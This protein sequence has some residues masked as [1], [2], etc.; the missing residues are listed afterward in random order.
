MM[1]KYKDI[2]DIKIHLEKTE[3]FPEDDYKWW[4]G[5]FWGCFFCGMITAEQR[6]VLL[7]DLY[8]K[9]EGRVQ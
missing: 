2:E 4:I 5:V 7:S 8:E 9:Y 6:K 3:E 1:A